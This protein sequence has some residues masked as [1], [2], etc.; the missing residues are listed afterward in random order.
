MT[1]KIKREEKIKRRKGLLPQGI[2][3]L[4]PFFVLSVHLFKE[5]TR[6]AFT[7][8]LLVPAPIVLDICHVIPTCQLRKPPGGSPVPSA[9]PTR[10]VR[11]FGPVKVV[12][13]LLPGF[14]VLQHHLRE[15]FFPLGKGSVRKAR[16]LFN[17]LKVRDNFESVTLVDKEGLTFARVI[18]FCR[19]L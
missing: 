18:H 3:L 19:V 17:A 7:L 11:Q 8:E 9:L 16:Q 1:K 15:E 5:S 13:F 2:L 10:V 14:R 12:A 6:L 4:P